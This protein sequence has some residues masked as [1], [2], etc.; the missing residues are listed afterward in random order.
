MVKEKGL[1]LMFYRQIGTTEEPY[2]WYSMENWTLLSREMRSKD[3]T[4]GLA[5]FHWC[6]NIR[7][8]R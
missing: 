7:G 4:L 6:G 2:D 8:R 1:A 5:Y 3:D